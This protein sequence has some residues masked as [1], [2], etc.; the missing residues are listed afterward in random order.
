MNLIGMARRIDGWLGG[1]EKGLILTVF[2]AL[3]VVETLAIAGRNLFGISLPLLDEASPALVLWLALAGASAALGQGRHI[4]LELVL[5]HC[6]QRTRAIAARITGAFAFVLFLV[7]FVCGLTFVRNEIGLFGPKGWVAVIFPLFF[8][9]AMIRQACQF[10]A[11]VLPVPPVT[12][13]GAP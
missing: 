12:G 5:R 9:L 11:P 10:I 8:A 2:A 13:T 7:L 1:L 4:R 3:V 6:G